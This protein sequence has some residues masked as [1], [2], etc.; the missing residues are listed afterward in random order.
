MLDSD[1]SSY[2]EKKKQM[3]K[4]RHD[5]E[6]YFVI[7]AATAAAEPVTLSAA[8]KHGQRLHKLDSDTADMKDHTNNAT[9]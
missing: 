2:M 5:R 3:N 7:S 4:N 9:L 8:N 6:A 1:K